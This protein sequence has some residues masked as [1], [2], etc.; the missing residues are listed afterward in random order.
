MVDQHSKTPRRPTRSGFTLVEM[1]SSLAVMGILFGAIM[2]LMMLASKATYDP[3][4]RT[5]VMLDS[6]RVEDRLASDLFA[7]TEIIAATPTSIEFKVADRTSDS[8][9]ETIRYTYDSGSK[10]LMYALNAQTPVAVMTDISAWSFT[11]E[12]LS[13]QVLESSSSTTI[14]PVTLAEYTPDSDKLLPEV[15]VVGRQVSTTVSPTLPLGATSYSVTS[16][17]IWGEPVASAS[18]TL[19]VAIREPQAN[20]LPSGTVLEWKSISEGALNSTT[21]TTTSFSIV[22][23]RLASKPICL[24]VTALFP[25]PDC[26]S[27]DFATTVSDTNTTYG[28]YESAIWSIQ[29]ERSLKYRVTGTYQLPVLAGTTKHHLHGV[30]TTYTRLGQTRA[31]TAHVPAR[32]LLPVVSATVVPLGSLE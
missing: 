19:S 28:R 26:G 32:P 15:L 24:V 1:V 22:N 10:S 29:K 9:P 8:T 16:V 17:T 4:D 3:A 27:V 21:G 23:N 6:I 14:G 11:L 2:S 5:A 12:T 7:A 13:T 31:P 30:R 25:V 18:G 20:G